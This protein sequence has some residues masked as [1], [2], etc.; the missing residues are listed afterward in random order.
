MIFI[1][2]YFED[3][4]VE[5]ITM[6]SIIYCKSAVIIIELEIL[7]EPNPFHGTPPININV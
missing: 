3:Y 6:L 2:F 1:S 7:L 4:M 5:E